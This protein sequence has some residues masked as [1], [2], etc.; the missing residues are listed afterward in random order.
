M[1]VG[2]VAWY[3]RGQWWVGYHGKVGDAGGLDSIVCDGWFVSCNTQKK[4]E[5]V[6]G[7][8]HFMWEMLDLKK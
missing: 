2:W 8:P 4:W 6:T 7:R 5:D 1:P 3:G